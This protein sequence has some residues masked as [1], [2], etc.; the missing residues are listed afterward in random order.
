MTVSVGRSGGT[1][2]VWTPHT[3]LNLLSWHESLSFPPAWLLPAPP[4]PKVDFTQRS[5]NVWGE[6]VVP[7]LKL[8]SWGLRERPG[9]SVPWR[10]SR[11]RKDLGVPPRWVQLSLRSYLHLWPFK[12]IKM[13]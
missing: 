2:V 7:R 3:E 11:S 6:G 12:Y 8:H 10:V 4:P 13:T 5:V 9:G 1:I